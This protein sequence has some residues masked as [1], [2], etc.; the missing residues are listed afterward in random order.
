MRP[1]LALLLLSCSLTAVSA[2]IYRFVDKDGRVVFTDEPI[3]GARPVHVD[4]A[5]PIHLVIPKSPVS[6]ATAPAGAASS[7]MPEG[8][9]RAGPAD[10]PAAAPAPAVYRS[11]KVLEPAERTAGVGGLLKVRLGLEPPLDAARGHGVSVFLDGH[12]VVVR[13]Q[14]MVHAVPDV[15]PGKHSV[16]AVV[17]DGEGNELLR[18]EERVF[19]FAPAPSGATSSTPATAPAPSLAPQP[20]PGGG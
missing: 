13:S 6:P 20:A 3:K 11:L 4:P 14:G 1:I 15:E 16:Q 10:A 19:E 2:E 7:A 9:T 12:P 8:I 5:P 18:G 17:F